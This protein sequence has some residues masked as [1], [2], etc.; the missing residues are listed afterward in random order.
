MRKLPTSIEILGNTIT[1]EHIADISIYGDRY[2]YWH[3][4]Q[5]LI[6]VQAL[7]CGIPKDVCFAAYCHEVEH[8]KLDLTGHTELSS[9][10]GL[11]EALG[12]AAY[13]AEKSRKY[14]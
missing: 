1:V 6:R 5:N 8:A 2:A 11:V 13:Q 7:D 14:G 4:Q 9:D 3:P 10:E 12:Q